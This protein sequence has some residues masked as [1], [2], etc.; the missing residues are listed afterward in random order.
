[1]GLQL[2]RVCVVG[3][4]VSGLSCAIRLKKRGHQVT[5]LA[6]DEGPKTTSSIAA[7]FWYPFAPGR[8]PVHNWYK[9]EWAVRSYNIFQSLLSTPRTGISKVKLYEYFTDD[10]PD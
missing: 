9:H 8:V 10:V 6:R 2:K 5:I 1:M 7:A 4:G 3:G